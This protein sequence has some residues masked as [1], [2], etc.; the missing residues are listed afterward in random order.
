TII[1]FLLVWLG[2]SSIVQHRSRNPTFSAF[3]DILMFVQAKTCL[4]L[5]LALLDASVVGGLDLSFK[6]H[7]STQD[8]W[9]LQCEDLFSK[10]EDAPDGKL[11]QYSQLQLRG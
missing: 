1:A 7:S 8:G 11:L 6:P 3:G 5:A 2:D 4:L 9:C 10:L